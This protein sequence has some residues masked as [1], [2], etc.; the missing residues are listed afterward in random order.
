[1]IY[2]LEPLFIVS[3]FHIDFP[4]FFS[5]PYSRASFKVLNFSASFPEFR[6]ILYFLVYFDR[7]V[8]ICLFL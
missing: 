1:M 8:F 2:F 3:V 5:F 7:F 6:R 4:E